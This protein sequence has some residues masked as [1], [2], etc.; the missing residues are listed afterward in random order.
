MSITGAVASPFVPIHL[1]VDDVPPEY[2]QHRYMT[3]DSDR[4]FLDSEFAPLEA[5]RSAFRTHKRLL[6]H[7][8]E[9]PELFLPGVTADLESFEDGLLEELPTIEAQATTLFDS[10]QSDS[11]RSLLTGHSNRRLMAALSLGEAMVQR[12]ESEAR[13]RFA[14]R[15]PDVDV[16]EGASWRAESEP[17]ILGPGRTYHRCFVPGLAEYPR[18]HGSYESLVSGLASRAMN[19]T[20]SRGWLSFTLVA[21]IA[22]LVGLAGGRLIGR[23]IKLPTK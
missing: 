13:E 1:G 7:T 15:M 10:N 2:K 22:L 16:P 11:A 20:L 19:G 17:M 3:K 18:S 4:E 14:V 5:T 23:G 12:V 21:L 8:C 6:Y 9:S